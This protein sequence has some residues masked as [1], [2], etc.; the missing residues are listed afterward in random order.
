MSKAL[1]HPKLTGIVP[2]EWLSDK[3]RERLVG[4]IVGG[5]IPTI[6][7]V[8]WFTSSEV[9][10]PRSWDVQAGSGVCEL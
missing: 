7:A 5:L 8:R 3:E 10:D 1:A 2:I 4:Q 9:N 6:E